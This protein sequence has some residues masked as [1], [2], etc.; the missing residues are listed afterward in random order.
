MY[1]LLEILNA[2][3]EVS[4]R[5]PFAVSAML[6]INELRI[7]NMAEII[8]KRTQPLDRGSRDCKNISKERPQ[9]LFATPAALASVGSKVVWAVT[10][11]GATGG[12]LFTEHVYLHRAWS[13]GHRAACTYMS[14]NEAAENKTQA[15]NW[16][17]SARPSS[18]RTTGE[19]QFSRAHDSRGLT[20][21][22]STK[23]PQACHSKL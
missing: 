5:K 20:F 16:R 15:E 22:F 23:E 3:G 21:D 4:L 2:Q 14:K 13:H 18:S 9:V 12:R 1:Q 11:L 8:N 6:H 7:W 19:R 10:T 17:A